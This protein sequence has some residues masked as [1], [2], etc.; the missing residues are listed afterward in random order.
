MKGVL[1]DTV[2]HFTSDSWL[3]HCGNCIFTFETTYTLIAHKKQL[4]NCNFAIF[5][6]PLLVHLLLRHNVL[7]VMHWGCIAPVFLKKMLF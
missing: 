7:S 1:K 2:M 4:Q 3:C 6:S 5:D